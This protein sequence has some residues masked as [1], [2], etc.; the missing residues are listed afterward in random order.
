MLPGRAGR[1]GHSGAAAAQRTDLALLDVRA[2]FDADA[3]LAPAATDP[4]LQASPDLIGWISKPENLNG[5]HT[6]IQV[7][8]SRPESLFTLHLDA[9]INMD[10]NAPDK[11]DGTLTMPAEAWLRLVAGRL[12]PEHTPSDVVTTGT[13]DLNVLRQVFPGY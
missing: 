4:L 3:T 7:T 13:A 10:F 9:Q 5:Q 11:P 12:S 1:C 2:G 6:V 8:T